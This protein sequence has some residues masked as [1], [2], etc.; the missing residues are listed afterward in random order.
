[1]SWYNSDGILVKY[2]TEEATPSTAG[3]YV[4]TGPQRMAEFDV[5]LTGLADAAAIA[6]DYIVL[7][8]GALI[9]KI[10]VVVK[11]AATS[12]GSAVL[13]VGIIDLDRSSNGDDDALIAALALTSI[14]AIG[15]VV[16]LI[17]GGTSH[18]ASVGTVLTGPV[19]VTASYDTAAFTAGVVSIRIFYSF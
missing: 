15:D 19:L 3:H 11:T 8:E 1:M 10:D 6:D 7:P 5:T 18:G 2:G 17:Q 14:D 12:G 9:E 4:T 16:E 13:D